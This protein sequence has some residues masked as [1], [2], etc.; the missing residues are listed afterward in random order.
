[1]KTHEKA[2]ALYHAIEAAGASE[3]LTRISVLA[4]ELR[5]EIEAY[6]PART[7]MMAAVKAVRKAFG[8]PGDYGYSCKE[9]KALCELYDAHN[10]LC[11]T[12]PDEPEAVAA[13][14]QS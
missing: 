1:M 12:I 5:K 9:G 8:P 3:Q 10:A 4:S 14:A 6:D 7:R 11:D 13:P 2:L